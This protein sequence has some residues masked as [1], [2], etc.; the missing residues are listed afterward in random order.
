MCGSVSPTPTIRIHLA[1]RV[2]GRP[3]RLVGRSLPTSCLQLTRRR[4]RSRHP[5]FAGRRHRLDGM[6]NPSPPP[7]VGHSCVG[8]CRRHRQSAFTSPGESGVTHAVSS[9]VR[10]RHPFSSSLGAVCALGILP[11]LAGDAA[12]TAWITPPCMRG[13][14]S[15]TPAI[16]VHLT[17]RVRGC[18]RRLQ[19]TSR[20]CGSGASAGRPRMRRSSATSSAVSGTKTIGSCTRS[21]STI[22]Q[23]AMR[24]PAKTGARP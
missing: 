4:L 23:P 24:L 10:F 1:G 3:R 13:S 11:A 9:D 2:R 6:G 15:P 16:R 17:G 5:A 14:V 18:P 7:W 8:R 20:R 12:S 19:P 22:R 21:G